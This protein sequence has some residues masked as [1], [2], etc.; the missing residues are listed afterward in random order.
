MQSAFG[1]AAHEDRQLTLDEIVKTPNLYL[2]AVIEEIS[3]IFVRALSL[4]CTSVI[5]ASNKAALFAFLTGPELEPSGNIQM[6]ILGLDRGSRFP[7]SFELLD[8]PLLLQSVR[9]F[10][11]T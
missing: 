1:D 8:R 3:L 6:R 9:D 2:E 10:L 11:L 5:L 4:L 7:K